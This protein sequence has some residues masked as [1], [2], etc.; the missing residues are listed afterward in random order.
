[1]VIG[2]YPQAPFMSQSHISI[3]WTPGA[4]ADHMILLYHIC[5]IQIL[6]FNYSLKTTK[7]YFRLSFTFDT[8][9]HQ[10]KFKKIFFIILRRQAILALKKG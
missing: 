5:T 3:L 10:S 6:H 2:V 8:I 1:M 4:N 7:L 9:A